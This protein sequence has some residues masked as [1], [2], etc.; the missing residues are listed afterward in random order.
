MEL[1]LG[2]SL[3]SFLSILL[4]F[5]GLDRILSSRTSVIES[6]LDRYASRTAGIESE[7]TTSGEKSRGGLARLNKIIG[8]RGGSQKLAT[9]LAR[10]DLKL[11]PSE[12]VLLN[13]A[14]TLAGFLII[15]LVTR[16]N[17][18]GS[19]V[20]GLLGFYLPRLYIRRL[21]AGRLNA[22]NNQLGDTL[23]LL[24]NSLRSGYALLQSMETVSKELAPP[25][26]VEFARVVREIGLGLGLE[27][28]LN[29]MLQRIPS[30][31]LDMAITTINI[32]HEV[33]GNLA[34]IL[35]TIAHTIRERV[36]IKGQIRALTASQ[37]MSGNVV[38]ILPIALGAFMTVFNPGYIGRMF[39]ESCGVIMLII[40]G[41]M[42]VSGYFA[43][44]KI[45]QIEV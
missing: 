1:A 29:H 12:F 34:E 35:D 4:V 32:Q 33:G 21:Q 16:T 38:A 43:I 30:E 3:M 26:S 39:T 9:E 13:V 11:T 18:V 7:L 6:R 27:E 41:I 25:M 37:R 31:D 28:A 20:G 24:S 17:L 40:G 23:V 2:F 42:I 15:L 36:R 8:S 14:T 45:T 44:R 19:L 5:F 22:F 10:A